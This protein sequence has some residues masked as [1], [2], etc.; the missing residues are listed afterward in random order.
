MPR[1]TR[2]N[3][4]PGQREGGGCR[5]RILRKRKAMHTSEREPHNVSRMV[6]VEVAKRGLQS[7]R[8]ALL[9]KTQRLNLHVQMP[10]PP[11]RQ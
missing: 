1:P 3:T 7:A 5:K 9:R 10:R 8:L 11:Q 2:A 6:I 4:Q